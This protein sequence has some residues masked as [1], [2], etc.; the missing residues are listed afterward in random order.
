MWHDEVS[1][2]TCWIKQSD[3]RKE[4]ERRKKKEREKGEKKEGREAPPYL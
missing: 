3:G 2:L 1:H 4:K